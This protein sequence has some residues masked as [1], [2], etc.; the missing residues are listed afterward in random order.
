[1]SSLPS[2]V[3]KSLTSLTRQL[4]IWVQQI[5]AAELFRD[6]RCLFPLLQQL[7]FA[8]AWSRLLPEEGLPGEA[9]LLLV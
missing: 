2:E 3:L 9:T 8:A 5:A 1:M 6:G 4:R 7:L